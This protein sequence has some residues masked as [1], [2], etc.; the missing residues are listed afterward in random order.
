MSLTVN[1]EPVANELINEEFQSI[2]AQYERMGRVSCCERDPEFRGYAKDNVIGRILLNQ[3]A[4]RRFPEISDEDVTATLERLIGE[5]GGRETFFANVGLT[6]DQEPLIHEDLRSSLRVDKLMR[7][8]WGGSDA[9][10]ESDQ[11]AWYQG[12][13]DEFMTAEEV[14]A[15]HLF[16]HV[17]K[18]EEREN[19]YNLLR[20]L[21]A[22]AKAGADFKSMALE[23]TDKDDKLVDLGWFKRG[24][25]ME[26]F[27]L[28]I[29]SLDEGETSPVFASHWGFH[30][31]QVVGRRAPAAI[32]FEEVQLQVIER[33]TT[34]HRQAATQA[35]VNELKAKATIVE[36]T[37][38]P[39]QTDDDEHASH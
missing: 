9:P 32:P 14:H 17:E 19:T 36:D 6:P 37:P 1:G 23:H 11:R 34:E 21:R 28:V 10:P 26:E 29:F 24:E 39:V 31:A 33:M 30:L 13:L 38:A 4:E 22:Q 5:H 27:D 25:F 18:V 16:K 15:Y 7:E 12:H 2:K 3:E 20:S 8:T 35:L